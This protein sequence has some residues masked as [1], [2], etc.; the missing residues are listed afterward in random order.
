MS[1]VVLSNSIIR[2]C[3]SLISTTKFQNSRFNISNCFF[4]NLTGL[5]QVGGI[6]FEDHS[7][8]FIQDSIFKGLYGKSA[9]NIL[10]KKCQDIIMNNVTFQFKN[11]LVLILVETSFLILNNVRII[12]SS[13]YPKRILPKMII[14]LFNLY[15]LNVHMCTFQ[16]LHSFSS[17]IQLYFSSD[18]FI[19]SEKKII[20]VNFSIM[21]T[22][23]L[24][25]SSQNV[26]G[27][28]Y[29]NSYFP[30]IITNCNF[31]SNY[32]L[33][34][35]GAIYTES[36]SQK[37]NNSL[38]ISKSQFKLNYAGIE[39]G[40][41]KYTKYIQLY[42]ENNIFMNNT[43]SYGNNL[44]SY[45]SKAVIVDIIKFE[46]WINDYN[47]I[48]YRKYYCNYLDFY[49]NNLC[50]QSNESYSINNISLYSL[51]YSKGDIVKDKIIILLFDLYNQIA[52]S[53]NVLCSLNK[54]E[55]KLMIFDSIE[56]RYNFN[57]SP[58][59]DF[60]NNIDSYVS[61]LQIYAAQEGII[62]IDNF[63]ISFHPGLTLF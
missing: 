59:A 11:N 57:N 14:N 47:N 12:G 21:F 28:L 36:S 25:C 32:A 51:N 22:N 55:T 60:Q 2:D 18:S 6:Y 49:D 37:F 4:T 29:I 46:N 33:T 30:V 40:A 17:P 58:S 56:N 44:A 61:R 38:N 53:E 41:I 48:L 24:F 3:Q 50:D 5:S 42:I 39:G 1:I 45:I 9:T 10:I 43:A 19:D 15:E 27:A 34:Y 16:N 31:I 63:Q 54:S 13:V 7:K 26:G 8:L 35:G 23:F 62:I 20:F 52:A